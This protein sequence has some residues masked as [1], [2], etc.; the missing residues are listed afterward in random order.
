MLALTYK[1]W[2]NEKGKP[3]TRDRDR[4]IWGDDACIIRNGNSQEEIRELES[5]Y[6]YSIRGLGLD[7]IVSVET[8]Q[9]R[10]H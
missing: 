9:F 10:S 6:E 1:L 3:V 5:N 8:F 4:D 2:K 7:R